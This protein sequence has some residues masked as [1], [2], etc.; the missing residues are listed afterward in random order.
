MSDWLPTEL[1]WQLD[2][3]C[4]GEDPD[5]F[6][7]ERGDDISEVKRICKACTVREECLDYALSHS[8]THGIWGGEAY[9]RRSQIKRS[10]GFS[11]DEH[12]L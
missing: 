9:K 12:E 7:P 2:A 10:R 1:A 6:F 11:N 5:L 8:I 4:I 3:N